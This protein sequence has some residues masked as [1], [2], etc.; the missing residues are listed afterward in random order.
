MRKDLTEIVL[1]IDRSGSMNSCQDDAEGGINTFIKEQKECV[2]EANLT[3][4]QFD[5]E[6]EV[7]HNGTPIKDVGKYMLHPRGMTALF[8]ATGRAINTVGE[9]LQKMNEQDRPG[10]VIVVIVTDGQENAST[11]FK[12][13]QIKEMIERQKNVYNWQFTFLGADADAFTEAVDMGINAQ[14]CGIYDANHKAGIMYLV[15]SSQVSECRS[16]SLA[17]RA[18]DNSFS[19][20]DLRS[21]S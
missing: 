6:Y 4:V 1:V 3:L 8:D 2:G 15:A 18:L 5:T 17:G 12:K 10:C 9:R 14:S 7:V 21:I 11:E 13:S 16:A 20:E 19:Q